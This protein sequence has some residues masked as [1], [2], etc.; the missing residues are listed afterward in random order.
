MID[1]IELAVFH[2]TVFG[3]CYAAAGAIADLLDRLNVWPLEKKETTQKPCSEIDSK[4]FYKP[5]RYPTT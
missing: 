3:G 4:A 2:L 5:D 1:V